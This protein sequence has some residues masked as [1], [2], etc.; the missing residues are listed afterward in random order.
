MFQFRKPRE[1]AGATPP[2]PERPLRYY[3]K[4]GALR[5]N[6][7]KAWLLAF[8]MIPLALVSLGFAIK[9]RLQPPTVIRIQPNGESAVLGATTASGKPS[10][11]VAGTDDFLNQSFARRFL[12]SYLN[13][14][15]SNVDERWAA[16]MNMMTRQ[17][18]SASLKAIQDG[19]L[20]T[21]I[22]DDQI[23]S[24]FH[25]RMINAVDGEPLSY[26]VYGVKD[27]HRMKKGSETTDHYV[28]EYVIRLAADRR[29]VEDPDGLWIAEYSERP[30]DGERKNLVLSAPDQDPLD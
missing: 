26:Q 5:A 16:S 4:D 24:V 10:A 28:D 2:A 17:L 21:K 1:S 15:P 9:V 12:A 13:Y 18:R 3:E 23:S 19:D 7:N 25:L 6:A 29:T 27:V 14:T 20:R 11:A 8:L 30:I 22:D